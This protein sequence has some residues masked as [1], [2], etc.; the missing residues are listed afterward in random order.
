MFRQMALSS[1]ASQRKQESMSGAPG[2]KRATG[3][4]CTNHVR[5]W[6]ELNMKTTLSVIIIH[7]VTKKGTCFSRKLEKLVIFLEEEFL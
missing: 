4:I 1:V 7:S 3:D 2:P 6:E 5:S